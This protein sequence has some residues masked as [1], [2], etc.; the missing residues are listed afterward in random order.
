M[1]IRDRYGIFFP[2]RLRFINLRLN[3]RDHRKIV[4]IDGKTGFIGGFNVGDEYLGLKKK[5]GY[6]RDTHLKIE[7]YAAYELQMRF[8]L[9]WRTSGNKAK[10]NINSENIH[11]YFPYMENCEGSGIQIVSSG[12]DDPNQVIKQ[13]FIR[14]ITNAEKY[15][16]IQSPYFVTDESIC[17]LYTSCQSAFASRF[18]AGMKISPIT[19]RSLSLIHI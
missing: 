18:N 9:D 3:Y 6:W 8:F 4:I 16:L 7:G 12:P 11:R 19:A 15:I 2:S 17:L 13:G 5:M 10:L 14:M 1:C